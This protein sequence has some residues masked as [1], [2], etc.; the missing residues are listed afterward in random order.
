MNGPTN[1]SL[2][3]LWVVAA[4]HEDCRHGRHDRDGYDTEHSEPVGA[5][6]PVLTLDAHPGTKVALV[7]KFAIRIRIIIM[8]PLGHLLF[9]HLKIAST[10]EL[11]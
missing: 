3:G 5:I 6:S 2:G 9:L 7:A 11:R 4:I 8:L 1:Q 10:S